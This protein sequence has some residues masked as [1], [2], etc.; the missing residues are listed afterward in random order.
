MSAY[1]TAHQALT[2]GQALSGPDAAAL[3]R[4]L[5]TE[6]G[7]E[8]ADAVERDLADQYRRAETDT[9]AGF[10]RKQRRFGAAMRTVTRLREFASNPLGFT[11]PAQRDNRSNP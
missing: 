8:L 3:L 4:T 11:T 10:R 1:N 7:T 9:D 5:R 6:F 2:S